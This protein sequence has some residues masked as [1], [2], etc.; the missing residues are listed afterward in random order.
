MPRPSSVPGRSC[1]ITTGWVLTGLLPAPGRSKLVTSVAVC[2]DAVRD[3]ADAHSRTFVV[4]RGG[5]IVELVDLVDPMLIDALVKD[6]YRAEAQS[7][8]AECRHLDGTDRFSSGFIPR[9]TERTSCMLPSAATSSSE[10]KPSTTPTPRYFVSSAV[11]VK[12]GKRFWSSGT[13]FSAFTRLLRRMDV[14]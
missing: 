2:A 1:R 12:D 14:D 9:L 10:M 11:R 6:M 5:R 8:R 7:F 3:K 4:D 13:S